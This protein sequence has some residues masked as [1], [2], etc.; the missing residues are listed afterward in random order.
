M[1][2]SSIFVGARRECIESITE[3]SAFFIHIEYI[4]YI[5][6]VQ[7]EE[8]YNLHF[9]FSGLEFVLIVDDNGLNK[10]IELVTNY[11]IK[12]LNRFYRYKNTIFM[13]DNIAQM[14]VFGDIIRIRFTT[15]NVYSENLSNKEAMNLFR[16]LYAI[17]TA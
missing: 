12:R 2:D 11:G 15:G 3:D 1:N 4:D 5:S 16:I 10:T 13:V 7:N 9:Y 6:W 8:K 14:N 17:K